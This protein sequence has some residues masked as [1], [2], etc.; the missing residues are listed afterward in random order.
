MLLIAFSMLIAI[1]RTDEGPSTR[2]LVVSQDPPSLTRFAIPVEGASEGAISAGSQST[3]ADVLSFDASITGQ[4]GRTGA[5]IGYLLTVDLADIA[6]GDSLEERIGT[7][8]FDFGSDSLVLSG[9]TSCPQSDRQ[10]RIDEPQVRAV[11]GGTG[12]FT[13]A[14]GEVITTRNGDNTYTH[15]FTLLN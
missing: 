1:S 2:T 4:D 7:L 9:G 8:V 12:S 13:G 5:L 10:M 3:P 14:R 15:T 6:S 11:V